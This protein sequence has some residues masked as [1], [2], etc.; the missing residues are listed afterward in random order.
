MLQEAKDKQNPLYERIKFLDAREVDGQGEAGT[1][2]APFTIA[3]GTGAVEIVTAQR[4]GKK[5]LPAAEILKGLDL[6]LGSRFS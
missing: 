4:E 3:C 5:P 6:P 1:T 2:I